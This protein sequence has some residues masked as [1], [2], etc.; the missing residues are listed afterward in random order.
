M[1]HLPGKEGVL[2]AS[3][4]NACGL[5]E[6]PFLSLV[7]IL[8]LLTFSPDRTCASLEGPAL[9]T[10]CILAEPHMHGPGQTCG[11][12]RRWWY[13][14]RN[15][16]WMTLHKKPL[17]AS[18]QSHEGKGPHSDW[19]WQRP[20]VSSCVPDLTSLLCGSTPHWNQVGHLPHGQE[21]TRQERMDSAQTCSGGTGTG[22]PRSGSF[23]PR[24]SSCV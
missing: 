16:V 11:S 2:W 4:I 5:P 14:C 12:H 6:Q 17:P 18:Q 22:P 19:S 21:H 13:R 24:T 7:S 10:V 8:L 3:L 23:P 9:K 15:R 20:V 1:K